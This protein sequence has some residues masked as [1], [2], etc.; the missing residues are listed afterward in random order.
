MEE[1]GYNID[2]KEIKRIGLA[3]IEDYLDHAMILNPH[4]YDLIEVSEKLGSKYWLMSLH[5]PAIYCNP[6]VENIAK[7]LFLAM[8]SLFRK[9]KG[10]KIH[11]IKLFETPNCSTICQWSS[12]TDEEKA[13]FFGTRDIE[14]SDYAK[15]K[16]T[17][18]YDDRKCSI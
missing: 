14:L 8:D 2:F 12:I 3:W 5:G 18:E 16:G 17:L 7:E 4:D 1:I 10:L 15:L 11:E 13:A 6:T 9:Q